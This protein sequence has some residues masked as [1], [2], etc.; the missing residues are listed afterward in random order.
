ML[1][2][3]GFKFYR[4]RGRY[5]EE[6]RSCIVRTSKM[7][8]AECLQLLSGFTKLTNT[9]PKVNSSLLYDLNLVLLRSFFIVGQ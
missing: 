3:A 6:I 1:A 2:S 7:S 5:S 4:R 9:T 8:K